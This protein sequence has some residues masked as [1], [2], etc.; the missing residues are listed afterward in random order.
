MRDGRDELGLQRVERPFLGQIPERIDGAVHH[1]D[2]G[3]GE[4]ELALADA[5]RQRLRTRDRNR[6]E[7]DRHVLRDHLPP[8]NRLEG[9]TVEDRRT[10]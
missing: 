10:G 7:G 9:R 8:R 1:R 6:V 2:A 5:E 3:D 4:P